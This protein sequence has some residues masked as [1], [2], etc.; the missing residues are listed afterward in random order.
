MRKRITQTR[1]R[2]RDTFTDHLDSLIEQTIQ[3]DSAPDP[4]SRHEAA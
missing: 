1:D 3:E 4:K 2:V